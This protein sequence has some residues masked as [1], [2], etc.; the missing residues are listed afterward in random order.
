VK[1]PGSLGGFYARALTDLEPDGPL[2]D[3]MAKGYVERLAGRG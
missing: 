1:T 2:Y 3:R